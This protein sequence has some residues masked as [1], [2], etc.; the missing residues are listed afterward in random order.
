MIVKKLLVHQ[1]E[2]FVQQQNFP[3][4]NMHERLLDH[5]K[6]YLEFDRFHLKLLHVEHDF[7]DIIFQSKIKEKFFFRTKNL[8]LIYQLFI[9]YNH[10][11][12]RF[13]NFCLI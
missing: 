4:V 1:H 2:T 8:L 7:D 5:Q 11:L 9:K 12:I 10:H 6:M 3:H 13:N